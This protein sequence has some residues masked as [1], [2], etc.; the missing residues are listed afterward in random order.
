[1]AN[2]LPLPEWR[3]PYPGWSRLEA[4]FLRSV[5]RRWPHFV[6]SL[7]FRHNW[8]YQLLSMK[9]KQSQER[10]K[11]SIRPPGVPLSGTRIPVGIV[12]W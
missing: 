10:I 2:A 5:F 4:S 8:W 1:M 6:T 9:N 12:Q 3:Q 7:T 11:Q